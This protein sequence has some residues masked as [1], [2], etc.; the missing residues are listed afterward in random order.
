[1]FGNMFSTKLKYAREF[2]VIAI[3][4]E[5]TACIFAN[6]RSVIFE[7]CILNFDEPNKLRI[8]FFRRV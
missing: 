6:S 4:L 7:F 2:G 8:L 1:M 3:D 5:Q